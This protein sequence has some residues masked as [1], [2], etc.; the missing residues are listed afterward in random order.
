[1]EGRHDTIVITDHKALLYIKQNTLADSTQKLARW[2]AFIDSFDVEFRHR[3]D[4]DHKDCDALTRMYEGDPDIVWNPEDSTADWIY[5]VLDGYLGQNTQVYSVNM[6]GPT[7]SKKFHSKHNTVHIENSEIKNYQ[8]GEKSVVVA[9]PPSTRSIVQPMFQDLYDVGGA[10]AVWAPLK[11]LQASYFREPDVQIIVIQ[12]PVGYGS[13]RRATPER[14]AWIT[15]GILD[16]N[17]IIQGKVTKEGPRFEE[18]LH[19]KTLARVCSIQRDYQT[20]KSTLDEIYTVEPP[21]YDDSTIEIFNDTVV[22]NCIVDQLLDRGKSFAAEINGIEGSWERMRRIAVVHSTGRYFP[23]DYT[24]KSREFT[25]TDMSQYLSPEKWTHVRAAKQIPQSRLW[26]DTESEESESEDDTDSEEEEKKKG[27]KDNKFRVK[28]IVQQEIDRRRREIRDT[29]RLAITVDEKKN[30]IEMKTEI[31]SILQVEKKIREGE[32]KEV[33]SNLPLTERT[34]RHFQA[35]DVECESIRKLLADSK[36]EVWTNLNRTGTDQCYIMK[37]DIIYV[38]TRRKIDKPPVM[39][40]PRNIR[41]HIVQTIHRG[42]MFCHPGIEA[43]HS[44]LRRDFWWP[45]M[46]DDISK[47]VKGCINCQRAKAVQPLK[48][49]KAV[50]IVPDRPFSVVGVD[51]C[52]PLPKSPDHNFRYIVVFVDHFSRWIRLVPITEKQMTSEAI[53]N[54]FLSKWVKDYNAP[55]LLV[56]DSGSQFT[57]D[58]MTE[59]GRKLGVRMHAFPAESQWRNGRVERVNRYIKER[60]RAWKEKDYRQWPEMIPFIEM[61]HHFTMMPRY[62]MSPYEILFGIASKSPFSPNR[63][64]GQV[65]CSVGAT[66]VSI[67]HKRFE[68]IRKKFVEIEEKMIAKRLKKMNKQR[69]QVEYKIN[70]KVLVFTRGTKNKLQCLWSDVARIAGKRNSRTY[71]VRYPS[72]KTKDVS[73]QRLRLYNADSQEEVIGPFTTD[74]PHLQE[75]DPHSSLDML[76]ADIIK[77]RKKPHPQGYKKINEKGDIVSEIEQIQVQYGQFI[78]YRLKNT[79]GWKIG[80]Y[81]GSDANTPENCIRLRAMNIVAA[82]ARSNPRKAVWRYEWKSR[83][84]RVV[85]QVSSGP[86]DK[87]V[88]N[89]EEN[90]DI[91]WTDVCRQDIYCIVHLSRGQ[92]ASTSWRELSSCVANMERRIASLHLMYT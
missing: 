29:A 78:A 73:A 43:I 45:K 24:D 64:T 62:G 88:T 1:M 92:L 23:L 74:F 36:E 41:M 12:G 52:G 4:V 72:G 70:D 21:R 34:I 47:V 10:W 51:I 11:V 79:G 38:Q 49:G 6:G 8:R 13:T 9:V 66:L 75:K 76:E 71:I 2:V 35:R 40:V 86:F 46:I 33:D 55:Q 53:A 37:D 85:A 20:W 5:E 81:L 28:E 69:R 59:L 27:R 63:W 14:G 16:R 22:F 84:R 18:R 60:M 77:N 68:D 42:N 82:Q 7:G 48:D 15:H 26:N 30:R 58:V 54:I 3:H 17:I 90:L 91:V 83:N 19:R 57:A 67:A 44:M 65:E 25:K 80:Q 50:A 61:A 56:S 32:N 39:L 31:E 89:R 87:P